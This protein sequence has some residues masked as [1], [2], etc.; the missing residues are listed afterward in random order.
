MPTSDPPIKSIASGQQKPVTLLRLSLAIGCS[1][2]EVSANDW[3]GIIHARFVVYTYNVCE[4]CNVF[5]ITFLTKLAAHVVKV[6]LSKN[7]VKEKDPLL[8]QI[9][10]LK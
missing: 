8:F 10:I 3:F 5:Y 4:E 9:E 6:A 7:F 1:L 2:R